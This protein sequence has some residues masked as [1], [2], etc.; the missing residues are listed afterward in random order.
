MTVKFRTEFAKRH[1]KISIGAWH[2]IGFDSMM[3]ALKG[4]ITFMK[5]GGSLR[6]VLL[7]LKPIELTT[8]KMF[9]F[10][11]GR[12]P[13]KQTPVYLITKDKIEHVVTIP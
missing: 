2:A 8:S 7:N 6:Q 10:T 4:Y 1:K 13:K 3:V 9:H 5:T 12:T 11:K